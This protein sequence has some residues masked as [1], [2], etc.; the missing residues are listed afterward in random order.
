MNSFAKALRLA[1][2]RALPQG[3]F[4]RRDRG[5]ALFIS[6][7]PRLRPGGELAIALRAA[8]FEAEQRGA[9]IRLF[10]GPVWPARLEAA[11]PRPPDGLCAGLFRFA[12]LPSEPESLRLFALGAKAL[13]AGER[14]ERFERRLRQRAAVCLRLNA[15]KPNPEPRG[16]GLYACGLLNHL[17]KEENQHEA[18]MAGTFLF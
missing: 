14:G 7:A 6:D 16:G 2:A 12:G 9:L 13:D 11:F 3:A 15:T 8:G 1:A 18:E 5:E 10:P 17:L 4:L